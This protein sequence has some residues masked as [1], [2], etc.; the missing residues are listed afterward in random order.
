MNREWSHLVNYCNRKLSD[1]ELLA[2][3]HA[4]MLGQDDARAIF[5]ASRRIEKLERERDEAKAQLCRARDW[6]KNNHPVGFTMP[7]GKCCKMCEA[8]QA[9]SSPGPCPHAE[10][11]KEVESL[12]KTCDILADEAVKTEERYKPRIRQLEE[13]LRHIVQ[14]SDAC[15][16]GGYAGDQT[17]PAWGDVQEGRKLLVKTIGMAG[18]AGIGCE[19]CDELRRRLAALLGENE[20]GA[21]EM[22]ILRKE[23]CAKDSIIEEVCEERDRLK[24]ERDHYRTLW[25][26]VSEESAELRRRAGTE[27]EG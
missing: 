6:L 15:W 25:I 21:K 5:W 20:Q 8:Y 16:T 1:G 24:E 10:K 17:H 3:G 12:K 13:A 11:L 9:L 2:E 7:E 22:T 19:L 4:S 23:C 14:W 27:E 26:T 18:P